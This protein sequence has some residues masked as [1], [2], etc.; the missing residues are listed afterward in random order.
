MNVLNEICCS[1]CLIK[2]RFRQKQARTTI[3]PWSH[4]FHLFNDW[5]DWIPKFYSL[6]MLRNSFNRIITWDGI[7]YSLIPVEKWLVMSGPCQRWGAPSLHRLSDLDQCFNTLIR[8]W[9]SNIQHGDNNLTSR[10][11]KFIIF[12]SRIRGCDLDLGIWAGKL[13]PICANNCRKG[14]KPVRT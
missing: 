8:L 2:S 6:Y 7:E 5:I 14:E 13:H 1:K 4:I 11:G 12:S 3:N 10:G 9:F